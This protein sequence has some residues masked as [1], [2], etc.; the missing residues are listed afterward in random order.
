MEIKFFKTYLLAIVALFLLLTF[1]CGQKKSKATPPP[2]PPYAA[3]V[4]GCNPATGV[5]CAGAQNPAPSQAQGNSMSELRK[6]PIDFDS[7]RQK[8]YELTFPG[9]VQE[10]D[11]VNVYSPEI[12]G[13]QIQGG[14]AAG[15]LTTFFNFTLGDNNKKDYE[16]RELSRIYSR[17]V[18]IHKTYL[19]SKR[20]K[21]YTRDRNDVMEDLFEK[22]GMGLDKRA[23]KVCMPI[24]VDGQSQSM[25]GVLVEFYRRNVYGGSEV[26]RR[27]A[28]GIYKVPMVMNPV[29]DLSYSPGIKKYKQN[30][31]LDG[32]LNGKNFTVDFD[33]KNLPFKACNY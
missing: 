26:V 12:G 5:N 9:N 19:H 30:L 7:A 32:R 8:F 18:N 2:P 14:L 11:Y 3:P 24:T 1:G 13:V 29:Y 23:Y 27:Q 25:E 15:G 33:K 31:L 22:D 20:V 21:N 16:K 6:Y 17:S 4:I 10:Q 28:I